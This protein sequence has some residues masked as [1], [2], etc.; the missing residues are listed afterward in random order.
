M[1]SDIMEHISHGTTGSHSVDGDLLCTTVLGQ[2]WHEGLD[3]AFRAR[4]DGVLGDNEGSG[5]VG[6]GQDDTAA[7][8]EVFVCLPSDKV[9]AAGI[10]TENPVKFFLS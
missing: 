7:G 2:N 9:L 8:G 1:V 3:G 5:S 6:A 4:V 10:D